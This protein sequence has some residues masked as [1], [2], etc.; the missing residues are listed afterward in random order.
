MI[1]L[2]VEIVK[3]SK[4]WDKIIWITCSTSIIMH[5]MKYHHTYEI[6]FFKLWLDSN[7]FYVMIMFYLIMSELWLF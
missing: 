1:E 4:L 2:N 3:K 6:T 7:D 5:G